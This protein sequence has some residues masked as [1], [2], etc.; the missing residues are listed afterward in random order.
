M[1][2]TKYTGVYYRT[3]KDNADEKTYYIIYRRGGRESKLIKE[4]I[5]KSSQGMTP[6]KAN[7]IR[8][9]RMSNK[10]L[11]NTELRTKHQAEKKAIES[12]Y[13]LVRIWEIYAQEN[14]HKAS[15]KGDKANVQRL[16]S[17]FNKDPMNISRQ[18][19]ED[20]TNSLKKQIS[21]QTNKPLSAQTQKHVLALLRRLFA[22]ANEKEF[23]EVPN[24]KIKMPKVDNQKTEYMTQTQERKYIELLESDPNQKTANILKFIFH[25]GIRKSATLALKWADVDLDKGFIILQGDT[26]KS[27]KTEILPLSDKALN[28][29]KGIERSKSPYI[30]PNEHGE[31]RKDIRKFADKIKKQ[32]G[33]DSDFRAVHGLR[34]NFASSLVNNGADLYSVQKLLTHSSPEMTQRYA[35]LQMETLKNI[36]NK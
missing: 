5:G 3:V 11:C 29:L 27:D 25:T 26:A 1:E 32:A 28:I 36:L 16:E 31:Q 10:E 24:F 8:A 14:A 35:H 30:F 17:L 9:E 6:A 12:H 23:C 20:L 19:I 15:I 18:D 2:K 33:L 21:S 4:P 7:L 13:S 22:Y 34:H